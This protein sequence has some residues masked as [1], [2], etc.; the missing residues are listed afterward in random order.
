M[1]QHQWCLCCVQIALPV[2]AATHHP[3]WRH[4]LPASAG[5]GLPSNLHTHTTHQWGAGRVTWQDSHTARQQWQ[6]NTRSELG[7]TVRE[8]WHG[9]C[10]DFWNVKLQHRS[11]HLAVGSMV[12]FPCYSAAI[13]RPK[14]V[15]VCEM[16]LLCFSINLSVEWLDWR[17][18][19]HSQGPQKTHHACFNFW[20]RFCWAVT[21]EGLSGFSHTAV[22]DRPTTQCTSI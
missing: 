5:W 11:W 13:K 14:A 20:L 12:K 7:K 19:S 6:Q 9:F 3:P 16:Q 1:F 15:S 21:A 2:W 17:S 22:P 4:L 8:Q 18:H 10:S